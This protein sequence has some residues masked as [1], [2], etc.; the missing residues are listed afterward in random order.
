MLPISKPFKYFDRL[1]FHLLIQDT[2][3]AVDRRRDAEVQLP[4]NFMPEAKHSGLRASTRHENPIHEWTEQRLANKTC[5][6]ERHCVV[7]NSPDE[8]WKNSNDG[9]PAPRIVRGAPQIYENYNEQNSHQTMNFNSNGN[10]AL[11]SPVGNFHAEFESEESSLIAQRELHTTRQSGRSSSYNEI[12][13]SIRNFNQNSD[14]PS[15]FHSKYPFC[16]SLVCLNG[17]EKS[18]NHSLSAV[19]LFP[20]YATPYV[21]PIGSKYVNEDHTE[22]IIRTVSEYN[23]FHSPGSDNSK[24]EMISRDLNKHPKEA[25]IL[26]SVTPIDDCLESTTRVHYGGKNHPNYVIKTPTDANQ[27]KQN[28]ASNTVEPDN[29]TL[30]VHSAESA[31][32]IDGNLWTSKE[33]TDTLQFLRKG[34]FTV[35]IRFLDSFYYSDYLSSK[36]EVINNFLVENQR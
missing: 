9:S 8:I 29:V 5:P 7:R 10:F 14:Q 26:S 20:Q 27:L 3:D 21:F 36:Y 4:P 34:N 12:Y 17:Q 23:S 18:M 28:I 22:N 32:S 1:A 33:L 24:P 25:I 16:Q 2:H 19:E 15:E 30:L 6:M 35:S 31:T 11:S 13:A